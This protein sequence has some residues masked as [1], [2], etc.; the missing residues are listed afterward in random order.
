MRRQLIFELSAS[1]I[2]K[3][4]VAVQPQGL[5]GHQANDSLQLLL[6]VLTAVIMKM[7]VFWVVVGW[8]ALMMET[9]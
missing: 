5:I 2:R 3:T 8:I 6:E 9:V 7:A 4:H 1:R